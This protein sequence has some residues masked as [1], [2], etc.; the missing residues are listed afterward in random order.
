MGRTVKDPNLLPEHVASDEKH[1]R[2]KREKL[3]VAPTVGDQCIIGASIVKDPGE[4]S[5]VETYGNLKEEARSL[6]DEYRPKS[7]NTDGWRATIKAW[8]FLFPRVYVICCFL[9]VFIKIRD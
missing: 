2:L 3:F 5:I 4:D 8:N 7:V 6:D 1:S 9:H